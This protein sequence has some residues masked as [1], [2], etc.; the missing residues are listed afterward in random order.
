MNSRSS[1]LPAA[2]GSPRLSSA[3][4][5]RPSPFATGSGPDLIWIHDGVRHRVTIWPD[6]VFTRETAPGCWEVHD[7]S[8]GA[9]ASATLGVGAA[10]WR[11]YLEYVPAVPRE[12]LLRFEYS[13]MAALLVVVRC[14]E[15]LEE[16]LA[17]P[18]LTA[19]LSAHHDLRGGAEPAWAEMAAVMEREGIFGLL[20]WLGLPASRQSLAILRNVADPDLPRRLLEPLRSALWDPEILGTLAQSVCLTDEQLTRAC[21][22]LAA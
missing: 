3:R 13:R 18:A 14:P 12:F 2:S 15:I 20:Q 16:L 19:F 22:A 5:S 10:R 11:K 9:L 21:H 1:R 7:P 6:V 17:T 8:E 4:A